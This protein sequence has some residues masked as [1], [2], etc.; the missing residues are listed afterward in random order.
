MAATCD[1]ALGDVATAKLK[2]LEWIPF[3]STNIKMKMIIT[4]LV[5]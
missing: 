4:R 3:K 5:M 2:L 1:V